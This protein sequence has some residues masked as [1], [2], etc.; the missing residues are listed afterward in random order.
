MDINL[1]F[2]TIAMSILKLFLLM[3]VGY[4]LRFRDLIN[5]KFVDELS[6]ALVRVIFPALIIARTISNFSFTEYPSWWVLPV[7]AIIFSIGGMILGGLVNKFFIGFKSSREFMCSCGFHNCGY[8]PMTLVIFSFTGLLAE[9]M[10]IYVFLFSLGFN[11]LMW[12]L[13]PL[14]LSG[15]LKSDFEMRVL[16]NPAVVAT[17][18][19]LAWVALFGKNSMPDVVMEPM[20]QLGD[21]SFPLAMLTIGAYLYSY[22]A[23]DLK[24]KVPLIAC[25]VLKLVV[26]PAIIF[27]LMLFVPLEKDYKFFLFLQ[28]LMPTAVSLVFIGTYTAS[29]NKFF[30]S[31]VFYTHLISILTIPLGLYL[32]NLVFAGK[33]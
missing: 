2:Y 6:L 17:L 26:F 30:S 19:A 29:D 14:F 21:A 12:S 15:K 20:K 27:L 23:H 11:I 10:L 33:P 31:S 4:F 22:K 13:V 1:T 8:L 24:D 18:F 32:F 25:N 28:S 7:A 9:K 5:D 3:A 16:F